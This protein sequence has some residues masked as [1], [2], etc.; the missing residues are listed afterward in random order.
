M[1]KL[2]ATDF[3]GTLLNN[4]GA[5]P[6][7]NRLAI[8]KA[9]AA[10]V[11]ICLASG[12][13]YLSLSPF[14][15]ELGLKTARCHGIGF[16]GSMVYQTWDY[17]ILRDVRLDRGLAMDIIAALAPFKGDTVVYA[18]PTLYAKSD[19][20]ILR[21]YAERSGIEIT[22]VDAFTDIHED[23]A[24][25][26][27]RADSALLHKMQA[28]M[29]PLFADKCNIFLTEKNLLEFTAFSA[30]KGA[31]LA[32]LA[33]HLG[34]GMDEVAAVGDNFNDLPMIKEAGLGIAVANAE[35]L[36]QTT[37]DVVTQADNNAGAVAEV[38]NRF[39][40]A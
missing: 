12:R 38:I 22:F 5:I 34:F 35:D 15:D 30:D 3:D 16:N 18:G 39:I 4:L 9:L 27:I 20:E 17:T 10:G 13:S 14:E 32:F 7:A 23:P 28:F 6:A 11:H 40:L 37:A 31:A 21:H 8:E 19:T 33:A 2:L 25:V 1:Y 26:L 36:V 24:K 29:R